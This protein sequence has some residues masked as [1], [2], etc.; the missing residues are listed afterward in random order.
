LYEPVEEKAEKTGRGNWAI[1]RKVVREV[2]EG[3]PNSFDASL[4]EVASL[5][6]KDGSPHQCDE[7]CI[8][9][10][11]AKGGFLRLDYTPL[12][13]MA[14]KDPY[15]PKTL[16]TT[17]GNGTWYL[18]PILP[19]SVITTLQMANPKKTIGMVSRAVNPR[20]MTEETVAA[21]GGASMSDV[22][23]RDPS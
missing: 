18:A 5:H 13:Q 7:G 4:E 15:M 21:N 2:D 6:G 3:W 16:L 12:M 23:R 22:L 11:C 19:V 20:A 17:T 9:S 1:W 10:A 8:W 14:G